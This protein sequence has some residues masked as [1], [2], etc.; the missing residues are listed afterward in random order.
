MKRLLAAIRFLTIVPLPGTWGTAESDLADSVAFFPV[1]GLLLGVAAAAMAWGL[2]RVAPP[3]VAAAVLLVALMSFS[4]CL[5]LDGLSDTADGFFSC[6]NRQRML[7]IM[8]DS[9][10]GPMGLIAVTGVLLLKFAA[11]GSLGPASLWPAALLMPL[12]GRTALCVHAALLPSARPEGL[13]AIFCRDRHVA[14][15]LWAVVLLAAAACAVLGLRRGLVLGAACLAMILLL[16]A[17]V[18]RKLGGATGDTFGAACEI[19]E[20]VPALTLTLWPLDPLR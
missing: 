5:H 8:K 15:A 7:E 1:V 19:V 20:A 4:G 14:A 3:L 18:Y 6:R 10:A 11:L 2:A 13:G 12:A 9:R 16:A 17:C